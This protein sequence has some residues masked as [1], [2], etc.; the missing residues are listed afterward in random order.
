[1]AV[2]YAAQHLHARR[3]IEDAALDRPAGRLDGQM[4]RLAPRDQRDDLQQRGHSE[5]P[6]RGVG[7]RSLELVA[8]PDEQEQKHRRRGERAHHRDRRSVAATEAAEDRSHF[9]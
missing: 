6:R 7:E 8:P 4:P 2:D 3:A 9:G 5:H 1:L